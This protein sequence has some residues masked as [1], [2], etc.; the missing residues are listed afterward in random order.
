MSFKGGGRYGP[1]GGGVPKGYMTNPPGERCKNDRNRKING[2][3]EL[4]TN[5]ER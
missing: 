3:P 5:K 2:L 4:K 1:W